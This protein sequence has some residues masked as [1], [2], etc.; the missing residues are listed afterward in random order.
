M[1]EKRTDPTTP[2][3]LRSCE[4]H[5]GR[6][7]GKVHRESKNLREATRIVL[8]GSRGYGCGRLQQIIDLRAESLELRHLGVVLLIGSAEAVPASG[9][10][11]AVSNRSSRG[12]I[13]VA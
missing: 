4:N 11:A 13:E 6:H 3:Q 7:F 12:R 10:K 2:H 1:I 8:G 9:T 5:A